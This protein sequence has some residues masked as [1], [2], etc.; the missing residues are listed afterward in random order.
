MSRLIVR[1]NDG[2]QTRWGELAGEPPSHPEDIVSVA[3][4]SVVAETTA[5]LISAL[6]D[7][8]VTVE[9]ERKI[10]AHQLLSPVTP[11]ACIYAQGL[12][13]QSHAAEARHDKRR[14]NQ[15]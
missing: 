15:Q 12:N 4:L 10:L 8:V 5:G 3:P 9:S 13:Y 6:D 1:Y 11:D 7:S 2:D 14:S